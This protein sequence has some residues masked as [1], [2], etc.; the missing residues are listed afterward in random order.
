MGCPGDL[1]GA[2]IIPTNLIWVM[3]A[4]GLHEMPSASPIA[5][6][7]APPAVAIIGGGVIGLSIGWR[8]RQAGC[9][10]TIYERGAAGKGASWA[11]AGMLAA[12]IEAEPT[13]EKLFELG[14]YSQALWPGFAAELEAATGLGV[15]YD[16]TGTLVCAFTRDQAAKLQRGIEFQSRLGGVFDWLT[17]RA[18][19]ELEP[20]LAPNLVAAVLSRHDHQ[21]DNRLLGAALE[22][23]F[24][25]SGGRL[26]TGTEA[27]LDIEAGRVRGIIAGEMRHDADI[28]VLAAGP[29][30]RLVAGLPPG[31][32]PPVRPLKGQMLA[33]AMPPAAP[34]IRHV[35]W[36]A[37]C[38]L[39][40]RADGRLLV[41]ATTE[42]R[43][44]D[45]AMTAGGVLGLL[46]DAWRTLPGIE[47]LAIQEMW[48]G[49]RPGSPDDMPILGPSAIDGL[50]FATGHHRNGILLTP[51]TAQLVA[52][53]VLSGQV[54][55]RM[56]AFGMDR[57]ESGIK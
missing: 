40:P 41:G 55:A 23:A 6:R 13:E 1:L 17:G 8:L 45:T 54:D 16:P 36:G 34:L 26:L 14:R 57:F 3:P 5:A 35:V 15:G 31:A 33:L 25:R 30:S 44:F 39:V 18:A 10:V 42:E 37:N 48:T 51:A 38:Y 47:E 43:G 21:V 49:F 56:A 53:Y 28:V 29:W 24:R 9:P 7:T 11:A 46:D 50:V 19:R 12:G 27:A 2:E 4:E 20:G 32:A 52:D 22:A